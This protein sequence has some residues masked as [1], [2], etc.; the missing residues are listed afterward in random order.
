MLLLLGGQLLGTGPGGPIDEGRRIQAEKWAEDQKLKKRYAGVSHF[1]FFGSRKMCCVV[2][3]VVDCQLKKHHMKTFL[4]MFF[5]PSL[6][7]FAEWMCFRPDW[8]KCSP[9]TKT[10]KHRYLYCFFWLFLFFVYRVR[11]VCS[12]HINVNLL[13][14]VPVNLYFSTAEFNFY[15]FFYRS[16]KV[17]RICRAH[18]RPKTSSTKRFVH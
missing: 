10:C 12:S 7:P 11:A 3:D 16:A 15:L 5:Y 14:A 13:P 9:R 8:R 6:Q 17:G 2:F 1:F 4:M 18:C